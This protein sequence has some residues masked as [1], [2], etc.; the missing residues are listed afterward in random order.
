MKIFF[1]SEQVFALS[2]S[3]RVDVAWY[4]DLMSAP[5]KPKLTAAE[6]LAIERKAEFKSDFFNGEMFAMAGASRWHNII[7]ENL[8]IRIR[9]QL[10]GSDCRTLSRDLRVL[11]DDT[12]L[13]CYPD[14]LIQCGKMEFLDDAE[15][16]LLNPTAIIEVLSP[17]TF[18]YDRVVKFRQYRTLPSLQEYILVEQE[19]AAVDRFCRQA[20][21][22]WAM[23]S[24]V[25]LAATLELLCVPV[26]VPLAE[27]YAGI[28]FPL[29]SLE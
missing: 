1:A 29:P 27:I 12:G 16:V 15:D 6:Y 19:E 5:S 22:S 24:F 2:C 21:G 28:E 18:R 10:W 3:V 8:S 26:R 13:Y 11:V 9:G 20:D 25:G 4:A 17:S 7:N 14:L 23:V